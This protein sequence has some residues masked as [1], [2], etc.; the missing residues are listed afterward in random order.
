MGQNITT[1][2]TP[3]NVPP[4]ADASIAVAEDGATL[5]LV[6]PAGRELVDAALTVQLPDDTTPLDLLAGATV[7]TS[8][9]PGAWADKPVSWISVDWRTRRGL[10]SLELKLDAAATAT[11][12]RLRVSD[13]G[14]WMLATPVALVPIVAAT[15]PA[16]GFTALV[17]LPGL[18]AARVLLELTK[19]IGVPLGPEDYVLQDSKVTGLA[20]RGSRRPPALTVSVAPATVVHHEP[21]L[22]PPA[23]ALT[24]RGPLLAALRTALPGHAGGAAQIVLR[25]PAPAVLQSLKLALATRNELSLWR[26]KVAPPRVAKAPT[27]A[28]DLTLVPGRETV[29]VVDLDAHPTRFSA[30]V[31]AALRPE[32]PQ[33]IPAPTAT[34][35]AH[36][37]TPDAALAQGFVFTDAGALIGVDLLLTSRGP[38]LRGRVAVHRD[39]HDAP[40][41]PPLAALELVETAPQDSPDPAWRSLDFPDP[42]PFPAG[43]LVW[44]SLTVTAGEA[45]WSL[46]QRPDATPVDRLLHRDRGE[47]WV[48]RAMTFPA[49]PQTPWASSRPRLLNDGTPLPL[50][51]LL[52]RGDKTVP[53][54][55]E[56]D[57][58]VAADLTALA[59]LLTGPATTPLELVVKSLCAGRVQLTD[60]RVELPPQ[61]YDVS[62]P[63]KP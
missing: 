47:S 39:D 53:L 20:L 24:L 15:P 30:R 37:C 46:A 52:R 51:L 44:L 43:A 13:G 40:A 31:R 42:V 35:F 3:A 9:G 57:G 2:L 8:T 19:K 48:A 26:E 27:P 45:L 49:G 56:P 33:T 18:A 4:G 61:T 10:V 6:L 55:A 60:L 14:P 17:Q 23:A 41:E 21:A 28:L 12:L 59:P 7:A 63:P 1:K 50:E 36:R 34:R 29:A 38:E 25:S 62:F 16:L 5:E 32:L 54:T 58:R 22:L 11:H